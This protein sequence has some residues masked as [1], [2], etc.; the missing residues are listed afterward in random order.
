MSSSRTSVTDWNIK[1]LSWLPRAPDDFREQCQRL[2]TQAEG[3]E[4]VGSDLERIAAHALNFNQLNRLGSLINRLKANPKTLEPLD[5]FR[6]GIL[7]TGTTDLVVP[8][9]A[10]S[11]A[12]HGIALHVEVP[13]F[14]QMVQQSI[15]SQSQ[16]NTARLDA[17]LIG[18]E[19]RGL[20]IDADV[21]TLRIKSPDETLSLIS[22]I[23]D[24]IL[25]NSNATAIVQTIPNV[26]EDTFGNIDLA[27]DS[28]KLRIEQVNQFIRKQAMNSRCALFDVERIAN[29]VGLDAWHDPVQWN[30]AKL[31]FSQGL[32]PLYAEKCAQ[33][34]GA[35]RGKSRKCL[36][37]DLDN[38]LWGGVV[39][40]DGVAGLVLGPGSA[41]GEAFAEVQ[42]A[43]LALRSRGIL[44]AVSSKND[45]AT[46]RAPFRE[47]PEM[48]LREQHISVFQAN[49]RE[50]SA[51]I[52]AIASTLGLGLDAMVF[53]DDNPVEREQVRQALPL[54]AVPELPN[55]P[56]WF[57]RVLMGAGY[58]EAITFSNEDRQR[59][60]FYEANARRAEIIDASPNLRDYLQS[61]ESVLA[62]S[63]FDGV[64][65]SRVAQLINKTNQFNL[66]TKRC[67]EG[68]IASFE[69]ES[70][71]ITL[72]ARLKDRFGDNGIISA[73]IGRIETS[74]LHI[75]TWVMSCRVLNRYT[76]YA[77][78]N[79]LVG[80]ARSRDLKRII[81]RYRPT[82]KNGMVKDL[83]GE[84]GFTVMEE[85]DDET[86]WC[87]ALDDY[88]PHDVPMAVQIHGAANVPAYPSFN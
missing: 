40:D 29:L 3:S 48:V 83:Y 82:T 33:L 76:E 61:L 8:A 49:W 65:R 54:V 27:T 16:L 14:D 72:Q 87:L 68:E 10:A 80:E 7:C 31:P 11:A 13:P 26:V 37:M 45:D 77:L 67:T 20:R 1:T 19:H 84:L 28:L 21:A 58:F 6:F 74:D 17:V 41:N 63:P 32:L 81:G 25:A 9:L 78:C 53:L 47:H 59:A 62:A 88:K 69:N 73:V 60:A 55:D 38:T 2:M 36:I 34:L 66:T 22:T 46:A 70:G 4:R 39:G 18:Y 30:L 42:R 50:K 52:E 5:P 35:M 71:H 56:A 12:R 57:T 75:D 86:L 85:R 44:L 43:A 24:G 23:C 79:V 51:N 15:D 64:S